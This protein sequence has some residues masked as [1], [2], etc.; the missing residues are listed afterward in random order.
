MTAEGLLL[1]IWL[2]L[3]STSTLVQLSLSLIIVFN[4]LDYLRDVNENTDTDTEIQVLPRLAQAPARLSG[5]IS[6]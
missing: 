6:S 3:G 5:F 4:N 1:G 2:L